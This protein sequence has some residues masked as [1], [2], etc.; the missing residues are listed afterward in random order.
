MQSKNLWLGFFAGAALLF[1]IANRGAYKGYFQDD[2]LDN[3]S[4]TQ[5]ISGW[6]FAAPLLLPRY[7]ENNFR[8]VGHL[9]YRWVGQTAGLNFPPYV[10]AIHVLHLAN[11]VLLWLVLGRLGTPPLGRA[12]GALFFVFH[13]AAFD[14]YWKP[15]YVFDLL[16]CTF[17]LVSLLTYM[18]GHWVVSLAAFLL[19]YHAKE[20][21]VMLPVVLLGFEFLLGERRWKRL[22]P[23]FAGSLIIGAQAA[24]NQHKI[25]G[26]Y[27]LRFDPGSIWRCLVFYS[28]RVFLIPYAGFAV[29]LLWLVRD[30]RV[31]FGMLTFCALLL[32][33]LLLPGRLFSA[34]LYVPLI[35]L[36][37]AAGSLAARQ[38]LALVVIFFLV[39]IPWNYA[40]MR[41]LRNAALSDASDR[42]NYVEGLG[43]LSGK[44]PDILTFL[45]DKG[46][47]NSS[48]TRGA[49]RI[50]HRG[51]PIRYA[52]VG[53]A[54]AGAFLRESGTLAVIDWDPRQ[55]RLSLLVRSQDTAD[56]SYI[57]ID[58]D[59]PLW[60]LEN[61]WYPREGDFR[62]TQPIAT[63]RL[64]RPADAKQFE[65]IV[66]IGSQ[67]ISQVGH[68]HVTVSLDGQRVGEAEFTR[69]GWQTARWDLAPG[70]AGSVEMRIRTSPELRAPQALGS[71]MVAFGFLPREKK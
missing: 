2:D 59:T 64:R 11:F 54:D 67:Y 8:P 48:G 38:N 25:T 50:F 40:N 28:S 24:F 42:R 65:I 70:P 18:Q 33:M 17:C 37:V 1:L 3:L 46:P 69:A 23:F 20:V 45:Y 13:M 68:S 29:L 58:R 27:A 32:P 10:A 55:H 53:D 49:L 62:W 66:N 14:V 44:R 57:Q 51:Q 43:S 9:F 31:R 60:Q 36:A 61:G 15:M 16:C 35:G 63:A 41:R 56:V 6:D 12:A 4:L 34:Y 5:Q 22:I 26:D 7:F 19:A 47:V 21:A 30:R 71:A 52:T 39:W